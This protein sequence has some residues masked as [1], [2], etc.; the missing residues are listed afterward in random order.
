MNAATPKI[1]EDDDVRMGS[2]YRD[3]RSYLAQMPRTGTSP[4]NRKRPKAE[5]QHG[6]NDSDFG[7]ADQRED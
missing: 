5:P 6:S 4:S 7:M 3:A 2:E 1:A